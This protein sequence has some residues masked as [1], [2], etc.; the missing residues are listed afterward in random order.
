MVRGAVTTHAM[1]EIS[2]SAYAVARSMTVVPSWNVRAA[3]SAL[4]SRT[5]QDP[6]KSFR[7]TS[8]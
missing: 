4:G 6:R 3:V 2:N 8:A 7:P 1:Q 5:R